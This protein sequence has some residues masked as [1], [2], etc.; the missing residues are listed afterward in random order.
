MRRVRAFIRPASK[1]FFS[2][3]GRIG[4]RT[5]WRAIILLLAAQVAERLLQ[6]LVPYSLANAYLIFSLVFFVLLVVGYVSVYSKRLHDAGRGAGWF[7]LCLLGFIV[8]STVFVFYGLQVF[9]P[10]VIAAYRDYFDAAMAGAS[11]EIEMDI[12]MGELAQN[13]FALF[14][15][16]L[17]GLFLV[18][19]VVGWPVARLKPDPG[20][21]RFGPPE[22]GGNPDVFN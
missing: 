14:A 12:L 9:A 13:R 20:T 15:V 11:G 19:F 6:I 17:A 21:N 4:P 8:G 1:L 10:D 5:F 16:S 22:G 7:F 2:A 18:N 3:N